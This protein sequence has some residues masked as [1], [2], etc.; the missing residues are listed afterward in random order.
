MLNKE[1]INQIV[2]LTKEGYSARQIAAILNCSI[3]TI[4]RYR[5]NLK[6]KATWKPENS[7]EDKSEIVNQMIKENL[8]DSKIARILNCSALG[9][10]SY[11]K[12]H[13]IE[14]ETLLYC[15]SIPI[16]QETLE[17]L[18]GTLMGD[19]TLACP[20]VSP[21]YTC[22]HCKDQEKYALHKVEMLKDFTP[23]IRYDY[24]KEYPSLNIRTLGN[25]DF[26][27][28][29]N[30]FYKEGIKVIPFD[31]LENFTVR[32]LAYLFMDDGFLNK[33]RKK[34]PKSIGLSLCAFNEEDLNNFIK[35]LKNKFN[36]NF[37]IVKHYNKHYDK[38]YREIHLSGKD[39]DLFKQLVLPYIR[40]WA[41]YK[42]YGS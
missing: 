18:I 27:S 24:N 2:E 5:Q 10:Y 21:Y 9:V 14:R 34:Q 36:L 23:K 30:S 42:I 19:S 40:D 38:Y 1:Q 39:F 6:I 20:A 8:S 11:R 33:N 22:S 37:Y 35:F 32:S 28:L 41:L 31:L 17:F 4:E 13:N 3:P 7:I 16:R 25:K 12:R 15:K 29:Y 26:I